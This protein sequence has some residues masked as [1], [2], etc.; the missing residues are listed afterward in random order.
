MLAVDR[1]GFFRENN[2]C[3]CWNSNHHSSVP[4]PVELMTLFTSSNV[5]N[6]SIEQQV[7]YILELTTLLNN[8]N[9]HLINKIPS[10]LYSS[11]TAV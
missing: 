10:Y 3:L 8:T 7:F 11:M 6:F 9:V 1:S 5:E 2:P 4:Q